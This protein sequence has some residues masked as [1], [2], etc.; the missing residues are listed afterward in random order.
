MFVF[1]DQNPYY[2][3]GDV[4]GSTS[5]ISSGDGRAVQWE[6]DYYPYG[7]TRVVTSNVTNYYQFTGLREGWGSS[8]SAGEE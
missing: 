2:Y 7:G 1:S 8:A 4:L 3:L 5:V 6:A